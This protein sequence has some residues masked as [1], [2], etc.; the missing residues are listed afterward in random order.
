MRRWR[1]ERLPG[2]AE[3]REIGALLRSGGVVLL[4]T[5]TIYGLHATATDPV[6]VDRIAAIKGR[7][8]TKP[9]VVIAAT[10]ADLATLGVD[11]P[12]EV[13]ALLDSVWPAPLTAVLPLR[14]PIPASRGAST[15]AVRVPALDWL[16]GLLEE[17]G[18]LASTSAN[19]SGAPPAT[20]PR[21][22]AHEIL[23]AIDGLVDAGPLAAEPSAIVDFTGGEARVIRSGDF[24]TQDVW[25]RLW[26]SR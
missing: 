24:F 4:P 20:S 18:P 3:L 5:D 22:L 10:S 9:F 6:A 19:P 17:T 23:D 13:Q 12:P 7:D 16:R 14:R 8:E 21:D 26:K 11:F 25:K 1:I 2:D 15:I